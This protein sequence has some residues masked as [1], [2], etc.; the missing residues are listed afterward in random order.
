MKQNK[1]KNK[2]QKGE[3]IKSSPFLKKTPHRKCIACGEIF[4]RKNLIKM[5]VDYKSKEIVVNPDNKI[6]GRSA[7]LC[8]SEDCLKLAV[9]KNRFSRALKVENDENL[10]GKLKIMIN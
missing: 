9:K 6:F 2:I 10:I 3:E 5:T 1:L 4:D 7:Y 8:R